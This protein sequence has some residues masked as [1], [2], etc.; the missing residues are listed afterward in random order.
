[1]NEKP[2]SASQ[3]LG[4]DNRIDD[5]EAQREP[6]REAC[7]RPVSPPPRLQLTFNYGGV[8]CEWNSYLRM[9]YTFTG[10]VTEVERSGA[11]WTEI[12]A[13]QKWTETVPLRSTSDPHLVQPR[14]EGERSGPRWTDSYH[15]RVREATG[16]LQND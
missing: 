1:M 16:C 14:P 2:V 11:K 4:A 15:N 12:K 9:R 5:V 7:E 3:Y 6:A 13:V 10:R 8:E